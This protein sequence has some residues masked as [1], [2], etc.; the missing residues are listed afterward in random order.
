M[1]GEDDALDTRFFCQELLNRHGQQVTLNGFCQGGYQALAALLAGEVDGLVDALITCVTPVDG[2]RSKT[3]TDFISRLP[4]R[5]RDLRYSFK[6][7]PNGNVVVDGSLLSWVYR[8]RK[9][10]SESPIPSFHRD[11]AMFEP[12]AGQHARIS[13]TAA[14]IN[15]WIKYDQADLPVGIVKMSFDSYTVPIDGE[16]TLPITLFGRK[17][18]LKRLEE[19]KIPWLICIADE[20]DLV[21]R[22]ASLAALDYIDAEVSVFPKGHASLA[23]SWS[24]PTSACA[25]HLRYRLPHRPP[26][27]PDKEYRGPVCFQ[28]DLDAA[29]GTSGPSCGQASDEKAPPK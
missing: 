19:K 23:T 27:D 11:L 4:K 26:S 17:L 13:K 1:T 2:T 8:L 7:L 21:D 5:F 15:H 3:L 20:D 6:K 24:D 25:P 10:E 28:I 16:G 18:N 9:L 29:T 22:E 12:P 14:A